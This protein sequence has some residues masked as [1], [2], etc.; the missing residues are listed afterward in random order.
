MRTS[1]TSLIPTRRAIVA[2]ACAL[3]LALGLA[4]VPPTDAWADSS[5]GRGWKRHKHGRGHPT[6][7]V[8]RHGSRECAV[9]GPD[10]AYRSYAYGCNFCDARY[11][12][13]GA[14]RNHVAGCDHRPADVQIVYERWD[15]DN[16]DDPEFCG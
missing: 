13:W 9:F 2:T 8:H 7:V 5:R 11:G 4:L 1:P 14:W 16:W 6:F 3:S 10:A 12:S 15:D